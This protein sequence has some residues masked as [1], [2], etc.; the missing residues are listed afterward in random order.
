MKIDSPEKAHIS[1]LLTLWKTAFGDHDGFWEMFLDTA[2][3]AEHCR[4]VME[5]DT[6][7]AALYWF[8]CTCGGQHCAY[9][10]AVVTH[11]G[12]RN[13]GLCRRLLENTHAHLASLGVSSVLLV[14]ENESLRQMYEKLG[15]R[16]CTTVTEFSCAAGAPSLPI[17][18]IGVEEYAALRK[19][20]LPEGG[21]L[22]EGENLAFLAQQAQFYAGE[23]FLLAAYQDAGILHGM[24]LLGTSKSAPGI[25]TALNCREGHFRCPG[26]G[27][28]FAMF[29]P[30]AADAVVPNYF[31]FAFD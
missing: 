27:K 15:Y 25:V 5:G 30:L 24:E 19:E 20:F 2:F 3:T 14:P 4:C 22:Q 16:N 6:I 1:Q 31:G 9:I 17:R 23:D 26:D 29:H 12:H 28:L 7:T 18:A 13:R 8:P 11:P 21:V 10:Y